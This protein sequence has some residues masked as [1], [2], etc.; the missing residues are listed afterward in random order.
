MRTVIFILSST[1]YKRIIVLSE[2]VIHIA[3]ALRTSQLLL[4]SHHTMDGTAMLPLMKHEINMNNWNKHANGCKGSGG[5]GGGGAGNK[6][7]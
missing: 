5:G 1:A 7:V 4:Y 6:L 3:H 2:V